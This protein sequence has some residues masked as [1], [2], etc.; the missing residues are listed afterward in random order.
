MQYETIRVQESPGRVTITIDRPQRRNAINDAFL[1]ELN[2]ALDVAERDSD[3]RVVVLEGKDGTFCTGMDFETV[4]EGARERHQAR[5]DGVNGYM[6]TIRRF[7]L[8]PKIVVSIVDGEAMAGGVGL[9]A[10]S[11]LAV[12]TPRSRFSL[13]EALW[14]LLPAM[15]TPYLIRRVGFQV[16]YRM[17]LT[18]L[19]LSADE[20]CK[21]HL[22][23]EV[24]ERPLDTLH[25]WWLRVSK[26]EETTIK[27]MKQF[28][29]EM[30]IIDQAAEQRAVAETARRA[31]DPQVIA[32]IV[33][34]VQKNRFPWERDRGDGAGA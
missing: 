10:A 20:A 11:D 14:G 3:C 2:A 4:S 29:R 30:W 12:A 24:S 33:N 6:E 9:V 18:T 16:A 34:F 1:R 21:A 32:N 23:D 5:A 15:V 19:G 7:T 25:R 26:L 28:F 17:T 13:S 22:V 27:T 8:T 31:S